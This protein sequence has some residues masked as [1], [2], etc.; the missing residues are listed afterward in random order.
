MPFPALQNARVNKQLTQLSQANTNS[1]YIEDKVLPVVS[2]AEE[3]GDIV[4]FGDEHLRIW[5]SQ[6]SLYDRSP[7]E[8]EFTVSNDTKY[9]IQ[10]FDI[11]KYL[12]DRFVQQAQAPIDAQRDTLMVLQEMAK[13][14]REDALATMLSDTNI[15]TNNTTIANKWNDYANSDPLG[16]MENAA[17][18]PRTRTNRRANTM[19]I[20]QQVINVLKNHPAFKERVNGVQK[21]LSEADVID[22][23][24][25][26]L[27]INTIHVGSAIKVNSKQGQAVTRADVWGD[28][29]VLYYVP[30][31]ASLMTPS[32][33]YRMQLAGQ[34]S[35]VDIRRDPSD[36]GDIIRLMWAYQDLI[37]S[38]DSA[39][40]LTDCLS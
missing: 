30:A 31:S 10:Y 36:L 20:G 28:I 26:F 13:I 17:D 8:V 2:V 6:R 34:F 32:F 16:D 19:V 5:R 23:I 21:T 9:N 35:R 18:L 39:Q 22:I 29:C 33:G 11:E 1:E 14:G 37:L 27:G 25:N 3:S 15:L 12:P 24:K 40:L 7:H 4:A 38:V